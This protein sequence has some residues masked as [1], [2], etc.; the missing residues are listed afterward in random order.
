MSVWLASGNIDSALFALVSPGQYSLP[1]QRTSIIL[2]GNILHSISPIPPGRPPAPSGSHQ[3][4]IH[5][6]DNAMTGSVNF[7]DTRCLGSTLKP[8]GSTMSSMTNHRSSYIGDDEHY[9]LHQQYLATSGRKDTIIS[10]GKNF[11]I[12]FKSPSTSGLSWRHRTRL[13]KF[14]FFLVTAI[15]IMNFAY[16]YIPVP[17]EEG[18][19]PTKLTFR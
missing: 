7:A 19:Y 18:K 11:Q 3:L 5:V 2:N 9:H 4:S 13:E 10:I 1:T 8:R 16:F 15:L 17:K 12:Q 6:Q 14:L